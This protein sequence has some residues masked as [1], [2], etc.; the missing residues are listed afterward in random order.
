ME[1]RPEMDRSAQRAMA[2]ALR[3]LHHAPR[4]L[5]LVNIWD[6][7]SALVVQHAGGQA[8]ATSSSAVA[9]ALGY[10][11]GEAISADEMLAAIGRIAPRLKVPLTADL[12][13]G[14]V[15][16]AD[17]L[18]ELTRRLIDV[19]AVGL[20]LE[21]GTD[22]ATGALVPVA[23]AA[24]RVRVVREAAAAEGV[25]LVV[26][27]RTDVFLE[28]TH[29]REAALREALIRLA[30]F[31]DAGADCLF[32]IGARDPATIAILVR[33]LAFPINV[34][35][36]P[37]SPSIRELEALGVARVSLGGGP[38]RAALATLSRI[39][40]EVRETGTYQA[41]QG[42]LTHQELDELVAASRRGAASG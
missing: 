12:E 14:Y 13:A 39:T 18:A 21:D 25:P 19:G 24:E 33:E 10:P 22:P 41:L 36:A 29:D 26:N 37:G 11:D 1:G 31:R 3:D 30:A 42:A 20:N 38:Q 2:E 4:A 32:P 40:A 9:A 35:A 27:A 5:V 28:M 7:A 16:D 17:A 8:V 23:E 15:R 34:L 6:V